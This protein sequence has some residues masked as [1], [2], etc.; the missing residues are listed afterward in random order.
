MVRG[1]CMFDEIVTAKATHM[2][3]DSAPFP[4]GWVLD[5]RPQAYNKQIARSRDGSLRVIVWAC[6]V[7]RFRWHYAE[8]ETL[9]ILSG[10]VFIVDHTGAER[11]LGPGD[12]AFFPAGCASIWRV[13]QNVRKVAVCHHPQLT[14]KR[15]VALMRTRFR[16]PASR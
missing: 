8:N 14:I 7:G 12:T 9:H 1:D 6:T 11:R 5:G 15:L 10:E 3:L 13:T 16:L 2:E 4:Q